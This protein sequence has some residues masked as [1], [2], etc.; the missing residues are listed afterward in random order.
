MIVTTD[1]G[2][3]DSGGHGGVSDEERTTF[4]VLCEL[5]RP[6]RPVR[7]PRLVDI[8]PTVLS[9]LGIPVDPA[10]NLDGHPLP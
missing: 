6:T 5:D 9:R 8:A 2:H 3:V 7:A 1:H 4:V 10:W